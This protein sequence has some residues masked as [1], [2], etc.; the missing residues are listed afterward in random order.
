MNGTSLPLQKQIE[1]KVKNS[2]DGCG[3]LQ[4]IIPKENSKNNYDNNDNFFDYNNGFFEIICKIIA[5]DN[6][7][8]KLVAN[9]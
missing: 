4:I 3:Y 2:K 8:N 6:Y 5:Y 9:H 7:Y 1:T